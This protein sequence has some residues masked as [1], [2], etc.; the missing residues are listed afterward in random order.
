MGVLMRRLILV[1][2]AAAA[3][4]SAGPRV[5]VG[6]IQ[7]SGSYTHGW[8][9]GWWGPGWYGPWGPA[10]RSP[11]WGFYDPFWYGSWMHPGYLRG[12]AQ[13]PGMGEIKLSSPSKDAIV[14]LDGAYAGEA[15]KLKSLWLEPGIYHIEVRDAKAGSFEKKVYVLSGKTLELRAQLTPPKEPAR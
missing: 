4:L 8:G 11:Y 9:P 12:F 6:S 15:R 7:V 5:R 1:G 14:L 3:L 2:L 10:W 13:G